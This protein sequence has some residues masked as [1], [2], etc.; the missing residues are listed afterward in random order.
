MI[1]LD[2]LWIIGLAFICRFSA[3]CKCSATI[4]ALLS[5]SST[6]RLHVEEPSLFASRIEEQMRNPHCLQC[7][8]KHKIWRFYRMIFNNSNWQD[9]A[10]F[11][12]NPRTHRYFNLSSKKGDLLLFHTSENNPHI[13][14]VSISIFGWLTKQLTTV[15][16]AFR[17]CGSRSRQ[18]M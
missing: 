12:E 2:L 17:H 15:H 11:V 14:S 9:H 10:C 3:D 8:C 5:W 7:H 6:I 18:R 13:M 1:F 4:S 16:D